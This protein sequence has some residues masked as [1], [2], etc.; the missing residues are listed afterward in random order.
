MLS[1]AITD[2][3]YYG[4]DPETLTLRL[5]RLLS[6]RR[7]DLVR[8]GC[9]LS[10]KIWIY[11]DAIMDRLVELGVAPERLDALGYGHLKPLGASTS[12]ERVEFVIP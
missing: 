3:A 7:V 2:P 4:S 12:N 6:S 1:Y 9:N 11:S 5:R 8:F 10:A